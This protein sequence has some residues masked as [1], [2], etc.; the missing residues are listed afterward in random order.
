MSSTKVIPIL[1]T[2]K[3]MYCYKKYLVTHK[4]EINFVVLYMT[5]IYYRA[6][7]LPSLLVT[8]SIIC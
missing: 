4:I 1:I 3:K 2:E 5:N 8:I 7:T 6:T